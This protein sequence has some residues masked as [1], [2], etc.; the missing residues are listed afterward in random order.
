[1]HNFVSFVAKPILP[2]AS[3]YEHFLIAVNDFLFYFAV[4]CRWVA[5]PD[6]VG[7]A[8]FCQH[9]CS[10]YVTSGQIST[11]SVQVQYPLEHLLIAFALT[12]TGQA[13][14]KGV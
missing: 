8:L 9:S 14:I 12:D 13:G 1:M 11:P 7:G 2:S 10:A 4:L 6:L 5:H 3:V